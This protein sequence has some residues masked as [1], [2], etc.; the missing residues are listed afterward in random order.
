[1]NLFF[2]LIKRNP[3]I[4]FFSIGVVIS[5]LALA[6]FYQNI[7][8][9]LTDLRF[10]RTRLD[11]VVVAVALHLL[12]HW[13]RA[14]NFQTLLSP[15]KSASEAS[16]FKAL[17]IGY[18]FNAL[19]PLRFGELIR[20]N[21]VGKKLHVS[22]I[23]ILFIIAI[24]RLMDVLILLL[25]FTVAGAFINFSGI[26]P[27]LWQVFGWML[28]VS[29]VAVFLIYILFTQNK[30]F[31][32]IMGTLSNLF[33]DT[34]KK[35]I[36][37]TIWTLIYGINITFRKLPLIRYVS[38]VLL[39][40]TAYISAVMTIIAPFYSNSERLNQL[41][42]SLSTYF[43]VSIPSGPAFL[44][45]YHYYF[46]N[47]IREGTERNNLLPLSVITWGLVILP[48][49][50]IGGVFLLIL[51]RTEREEVVDFSDLSN[52]GD[53]METISSN[54]LFRYNDISK[55]LGHFLEEYFSGGELSR[56][57]SSDEI[58]GNLRVIKV[59][60]GGSNATTSLIWN[61]K[62]KVIRKSILSPYAEKLRNQYLWLNKRK[63]SRHFPQIMGSHKDE[64]SFSYD[65]EYYSGYVP[66]FDFI[67]QR[68]IRE[69]EVLLTN[70]I[71][72]MQKNIYSEKKLV[73]SPA[74]LKNY[75]K[76]KVFNKVQD[77][78][79]LYHSLESLVR[80]NKLIVNGN[81]YSN[82]D[83][84]V[85]KIMA[86]SDLIDKLA[87][88]EETT[89][90]G[91][92]TVENILACGQDFILLDPNDENLISDE[93]VDYAKLY[94]S[95]HS[96]YEFLC[97]LKFGIAKENSIA[98]EENI[99]SKYSKLFIRLNEIL[100]DSVTPKKISVIKFHEAVH[101]FRMLTYK[102]RLS[103]ETVPIFYATGI[104][105]LN[106]FYEEN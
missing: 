98:F 73:N 8:I 62:K 55:E 85:N 39:M 40:W 101:Y 49:S 52:V 103:P 12:G 48:I 54:K 35:K 11:L 91:D 46:S 83:V 30:M 92:L 94:Q 88:F 25:I 81:T 5:A 67:H 86:R 13:F 65:M 93:V 10:E 28:Q 33:N 34:L 20:A 51:N 29:L 106:E 2:R 56:I 41:M 96:G 68:S 31:L 97:K 42:A 104:K 64:K 100:R 32:R 1:M 70:I 63:K 69:S 59:I 18:L 9:E 19:L 47:I 6:R 21:I 99:S 60:S 76:D 78:I 90:H 74:L 37:F 102:A 95:L 72:Y 57:L 82:F 7:E 45:T 16:L 105:L 27:F 58:E 17:S 4:L 26:N 75:I 87:S 38:S 79:N 43:C 3:L 77:T 53:N 15:I 22:R 80:P 61:Q 71:R 50:I 84:I 44:G 23:V 89:I 14:K 66:Y 24:E 36:Q